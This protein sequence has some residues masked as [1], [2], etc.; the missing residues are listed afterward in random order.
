MPEK[1]DD[2]KLSGTNFFVIH[3]LHSAAISAF[4]FKDDGASGFVL[5]NLELSFW[6]FCVRKN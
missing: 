5:I 6:L 3:G 4:A 2:N 1:T